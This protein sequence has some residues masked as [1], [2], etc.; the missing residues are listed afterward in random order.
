[1]SKKLFYYGST[2]S[3]ANGFSDDLDGLNESI[4]IADASNLSFTNG[5]GQ[6]LPFT[7]SI[8]VKADSH[9]STFTFFS[10]G[11][12]V[13]REYYFS[14]G[15]D[16]RIRFTCSNPAGSAEI[17][18]RSSSTYAGD[19]GA[20]HHYVGVYTGN[21]TYASFTIYRDAVAIATTN[22]SG[23]A[24]TGMTNGIGL[25]Y[26]GQFFNDTTYGNGKVAHPIIISKAL[27]A[28]EVTE[29]YNLRMGNAATLSFAANVVSAY[30][31]PNGTADFPTYQDYDDG[32]PGSMTNQEAADI[33]SDVP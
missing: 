6:D 25:A 28:A 18:A 16:S 15:S 23:G 24:Y 10:K 30:R 7:I 9:A 4:L 32:N 21:E 5:A 8:W 20:Y 12:L 19:I 27:S 3:F 2:A 14:M 26:I 17:V 29:V 22:A 31:F 11:F 13:A 1:M 33:N